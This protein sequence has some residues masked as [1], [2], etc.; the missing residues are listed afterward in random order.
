VILEEHRTLL[1]SR[2]PELTVRTMEPFGDGWDTFSYLVNEDLVAQFARPTGWP[3]VTLD[4]LLLMLPEIAAEVSAPVPVPTFG[5]T[6]DPPC[7]VYPIINGV[8]MDV[9]ADGIWPERLGRFLYD[10]HLMPP[11]Y[12]AF[13]S[14]PAEVVRA[15]RRTDAAG[16]M[17]ATRSI[18]GSAIGG[19]LDA[20][21]TS[22]LDDDANW[23]FATCL[24][25]SDIAPQHVLIGDD[26]D[27]AGVIDWGDVEVGDPAGDFAWILGARP[28]AGERAL[29]AYGGEPD[30]GFRIRAD[31][32]FRLMPWSDVAY[33][34]R[35]GDDEILQRGLDGLRD[36]LG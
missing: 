30:I 14:R 13:R 5:S 28:D 3:A 15:E 18:L 1:E 10:L 25:H 6:E 9:A 4:R 17:A 20:L 29:G 11:E 34:L 33:G 35:V 36:R 24:T 16:K 7:I 27:L 31:A 26:G 12:V 2:F 23:R 32:G 8:P 19:Q 21:L 22:F